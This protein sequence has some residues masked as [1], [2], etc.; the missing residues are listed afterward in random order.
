MPNKI[1]ETKVCVGRKITLIVLSMYYTAGP[2][3]VIPTPTQKSLGLY[4]GD[5]DTLEL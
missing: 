4:T 3:D 1:N 5:V 2:A